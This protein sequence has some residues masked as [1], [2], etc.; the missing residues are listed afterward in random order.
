MV[1]NIDMRIF[2]SKPTLVLLA[3][4]MLISSVC[5]ASFDYDNGNIY[6]TGYKYSAINSQSVNG[7]EQYASWNGE[8]IVKPVEGYPSHFTDK[9]LVEKNG[10][11]YLRT[12]NYATPAAP[13][14]QA[15]HEAKKSPGMTFGLTLVTI[16]SI[17]ILRKNS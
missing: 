10:K 16:G 8:E 13:L 5:A 11:Y 3:L 6:T 2:A 17:L 1:Y 4:A 7:I 9:D 12:G 15:T 14:A